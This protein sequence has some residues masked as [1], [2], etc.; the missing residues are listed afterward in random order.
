[1]FSLAKFFGGI[2]IR[3]LESQVCRGMFV[4]IG[5]KDTLRHGLLE[6]IT[7]SPD[8]LDDFWRKQDFRNNPSF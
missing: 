3:R 8:D 2:F 1:M 5:W 7:V 4:L 6:S